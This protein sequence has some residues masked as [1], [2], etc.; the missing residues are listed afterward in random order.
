MATEYEFFV[1]PYLTGK[2]YRIC[3]GSGKFMINLMHAK[4]QHTNLVQ[5]LSKC[6]KK[7]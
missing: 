7:N 4:V 6:K 1:S 2:Y 5:I 3:A